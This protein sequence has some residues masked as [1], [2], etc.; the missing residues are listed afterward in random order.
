[1]EWEACLLSFLRLRL[2]LLERVLPRG[3]GERDSFA[4]GFVGFADGISHI[5]S[6]R[7]MPLSI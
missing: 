6:V 5:S 7:W 1:M 3:R 4:A 2:R